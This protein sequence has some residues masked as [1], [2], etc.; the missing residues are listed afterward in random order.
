MEKTEGCRDR[1]QHPKPLNPKQVSLGFR[2]E[3]LLLKAQGLGFRSLP[4]YY[5]QKEAIPLL[6]WGELE[7]P[8]LKNTAHLRAHSEGV[9]LQN[10]CD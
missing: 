8:E 9:Q 10:F 2:V 7:C 5:D 3:G 6:A 1:T 4:G